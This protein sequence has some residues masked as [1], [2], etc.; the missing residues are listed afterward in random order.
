VSIL[1]QSLNSR[2]LT[3][4]N[5]VDLLVQAAVISLLAMGEI[6]PCSSVRSTC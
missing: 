5:L 6:F 2:F 3:V 1:F 4:G